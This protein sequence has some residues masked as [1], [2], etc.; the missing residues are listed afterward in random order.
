[1]AQVDG[2]EKVS[3]LAHLAL[4]VCKHVLAHNALDLLGLE[5]SLE[6]QTA[7]GVERASHAQ[8]GIQ[9]GHDMLHRPG[10]RV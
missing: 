6:C 9:E 7:L 4:D 8:L 10:R 2:R 1:M 5:C 3:H